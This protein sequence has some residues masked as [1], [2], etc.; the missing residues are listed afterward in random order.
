M[1]WFFSKK[2]QKESP[3]ESSNDSS[4]AE[5]PDDYIFV[6][7]RTDTPAKQEDAA[8]SDG[9]YPTLDPQNGPA[10]IPGL[11]GK[12]SAQMENF[13]YLSGVPFKLCKTLEQNLNDDLEIDRLRIDE[14]LSF[15][16]R[17]E[18]EKYDYD[19]SH[20]N[21]VVAEMDSTAE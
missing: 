7:K 15:I 6:E 20:E 1:S 9:L 21:S 16:N 5:Q 17:L 12:S 13:N 8:M 10:V 4:G 18:N 11:P 19:F 2:K 14:I 3:P